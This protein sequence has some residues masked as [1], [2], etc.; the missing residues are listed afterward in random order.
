MGREAKPNVNP[1]LVDITGLRN[2]CGGVSKETAWK[3]AE[4]ANAKVN[5][6]IRRTLYNVQAVQYYINS[7]TGG[8][9]DDN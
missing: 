7:K 9:T 2:L 4:E 6:G 1:I 3:I 8:G 5:L